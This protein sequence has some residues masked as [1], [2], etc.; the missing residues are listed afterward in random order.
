[1]LFFQSAKII[2]FHTTP[3]ASRFLYPEISLSLQFKSNRSM[4]FLLSSLTTGTR[5]ALLFLLLLTGLILAG[6][7]ITLVGTM[8]TEDTEG[9]VTMIYAGTVVQSLLAIAAPALLL[10]LFTERDPLGYLCLRG[11]DKMGRMFLFTLAIFLFSY[12]I[13]SLLSRWNEQMVLP[14]AFRDLETTMRTMEDAAMETTA[15][16]LSVDTIGGLLLNLLVVAL[17]AA[18]TEELFF[19]G[20][21]QQ[22]LREWFRS[23][24]AAVWVAAAIFSLIHFQFYGFL[25]RMLLG[26]L[27]GYLFLYSRNLWIPIL[28]H[29]TNNAT[30]ILLHY[31]WSDATWFRELDELPLTLPYLIAAL[32]G[33]LVTLLL[34]HLFPAGRSAGKGEANKLSDNI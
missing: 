34:F 26:A 21:L 13:A 16:I 32:T 5:L 6:A 1:M 14:E 11:D 8:V 4:R 33:A 23:G 7:V 29:F 15:L 2:L 9:T 17:L 25:P 24:H 27:L 31:F 18:V 3:T 12:P 19:R 10:A 20:V 30:V 22:L 28:F